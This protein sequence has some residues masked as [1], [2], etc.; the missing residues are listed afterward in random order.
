MDFTYY[1]GGD[2]DFGDIMVGILQIWRI[3][4]CKKPSGLFRKR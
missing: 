4:I 2:I 1:P 3:M